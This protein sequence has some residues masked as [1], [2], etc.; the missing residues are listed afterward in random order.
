MVPESLEMVKMKTTH[1][2]GPGNI[3]DRPTKHLGT[4]NISQVPPLDK[5]VLFADIFANPVAG[6]I[7]SN[8]LGPKPELRYLHG[9]TV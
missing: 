8:I 4:G 3:L 2:N 5:E 7:L 6:T 1:E 9:N